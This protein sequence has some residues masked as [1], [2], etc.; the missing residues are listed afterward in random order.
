MQRRTVRE[1][2]A[3]R[4]CHCCP[5][6]LP[7]SVIAQVAVAQLSVGPQSAPGSSYPLPSDDPPLLLQVWLPQARCLPCPV[8]R[9]PTSPYIPTQGLRWDPRHGIQPSAP[10]RV[11]NHSPCCPRP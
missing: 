11:P 3:V 6:S 8:Q 1:V 7:P 4:M 10:L 2:E 9:R 5:A